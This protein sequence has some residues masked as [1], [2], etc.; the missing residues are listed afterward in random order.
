MPSKPSKT[1]RF[2]AG[3]ILLACLAFIGIRGYVDKRIHDLAGGPPIPTLVAKG[4]IFPG[5]ELDPKDFEV[6][7]LP[8]K[9]VHKR[10]V[11]AYLKD[12][13]DKNA[14]ILA[15][16]AGETLLWDHLAQG[17]K[18]PLS[19]YLGLTE[20]AISIPVDALGSLQ[21]MLQVG[22]RIDIMT[23]LQPQ[24]LEE[25]A[26]IKIIVQNALILSINQ[27]TTRPK[28]KHSS[29][30]KE[31]RTPIPVPQILTVR[32]S[33][34][35]AAILAYAQ[36]QGKL[37]TTLRNRKDVFIQNLDPV[38]TDYLLRHAE[39]PAIQPLEK[40]AKPFIQEN[41]NGNAN[42]KALSEQAPLM[43]EQSVLI[44]ADLDSM[45]K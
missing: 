12:S 17:Q 31:A 42:G 20:R 24:D 8:K 23:L 39:D 5:T 35:E 38:N 28:P 21:N 15:L 30:V 32:V 29:P 6:K 11:P 16:E 14:A 22:D 10:A 19:D 40:E 25:E 13:L 18:R 2:T 7:L 4:P 33:P 41:A 44:P 26:A 36:T 9:Y 3:A 45:L 34:S 37:F 1:F 43:P 27:D